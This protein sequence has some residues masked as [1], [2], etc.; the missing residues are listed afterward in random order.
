MKKN[1]LL[2]LLTF[3]TAGLCMASDFSVGTL[4]YTII[5]GTTNVQVDGPVNTSATSVAIP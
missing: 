4:N 5:T 1:F 3:F 2:F